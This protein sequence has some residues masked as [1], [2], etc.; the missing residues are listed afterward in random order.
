MQTIWKTVFAANI[1]LVTVLALTLGRAW[2]VN[3]VVA[4]SPEEKKPTVMP[5][6]VSVPALQC[7][8]ILEYLGP[9]HQQCALFIVYWITPEAYR[10]EILW[11]APPWALPHFT[12]NPVSV[13]IQSTKQS[14][15]VYFRRMEEELRLEEAKPIGPRG[16]FNSLIGAYGML[17]MRFAE[18]ENQATLVR[19]RDLPAL[20]LGRNA[21][22]KR[23][24][25]GNNRYETVKA[26][27]SG[28]ML[29]QLALL[30]GKDN[31]VKEIHYNYG[32]DDTLKSLSVVL[33]KQFISAGGIK[34]DITFNG[35]KQTHNEILAIHHA[36]G[37]RCVA[38]FTPLGPKYHNAVLPHDIQVSNPKTGRTL[39]RATIGKYKLISRDVADRILRGP[40]Q[41][42]D[43]SPED[44]S[45]RL[46]TIKHWYKE[47]SSVPNDD[48]I[49]LQG[50]K[51][52]LWSAFQK[53]TLVGKKLRSF[54]QL[55]VIDF[56][57]GDV[58]GIEMLYAEY[59][60]I[61]K[62][63]HLTWLLPT[64]GR[65]MTD[66]A[67]SW[68][69]PKVV[70][71]ILPIWIQATLDAELP[72]SAI[73]EF[74]DY[75][76]QTSRLWFSYVLLNGLEKRNLGNAHEAFL[77][78]Y[79]KCK[80]LDKLCHHPV[81]KEILPAEKRELA[82]LAQRVSPKELRFKL[83]KD[84]D[85]ALELYTQVEGD[86]TENQTKRDLDEM[87]KRLFK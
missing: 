42:L 7:D 22:Y 56:I 24:V 61:L 32:E 19:Q 67:L 25:A 64:D 30:D 59:V 49:A 10:T 5:L 53:E 73:L 57:L 45:W 16:T 62:Q 55:V 46:L 86:P 50:L 70:D 12:W 28:G 17:D 41:Y 60:K 52:R 2:S 82:Y 8:A 65:D 48:R 72:L 54:Y 23:T 31:L 75:E 78:R 58:S 43:E 68:N 81:D 63:V 3:P 14:F 83:K 13:R 6:G 77:A 18:D 39:R 1:L 33:P 34:A 80:I 36:G 15:A 29:E 66:C 85:A 26:K 76:I 20:N 71:A 84:L 74:V 11:T 87:Q 51:K 27:V 9:P 35:N 37:R 4:R 21:Q 47:S 38:S 40:A 44:R 79:L 69:Q